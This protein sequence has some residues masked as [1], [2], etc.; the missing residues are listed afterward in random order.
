MALEVERQHGQT[1]WFFIARQ[2]D[3]SLE[4]GDFAGM[5]MWRAVGKRLDAMQ[6]SATQDNAIS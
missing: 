5:A 2:Q 3:R 1:A 4:C 6:V